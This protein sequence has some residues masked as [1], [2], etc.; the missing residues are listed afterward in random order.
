MS[1][2]S[3]DGLP[4]VHA[5]RPCHFYLMSRTEVDA[6]RDARHGNLSYECTDTQPSAKVR[7]S[8]NRAVSLSLRLLLSSSLKVRAASMKPAR[9]KSDCKPIRHNSTAASAAPWTIG[10]N[11]ERPFRSTST[12]RS[13]CPQSPSISNAKRMWSDKHAASTSPECESRTEALH[14]DKATP[15]LSASGRYCSR[16]VAGTVLKLSSSSLT[17]F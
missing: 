4:L 17:V 12:M 16:S 2:N 10:C 14:C 8:S 6:T 5:G 11:N 13:A 3:N 7:A 9:C 1:I 15:I